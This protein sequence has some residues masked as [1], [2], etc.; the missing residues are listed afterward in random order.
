MLSIGILTHNSPITL[1]NTL[2]SYKIGG[3]LD[4]TNDITCLIQPSNKSD[5]EIEICKTYGIGH[6]NEKT[7]TMMAGAIKTLVEQ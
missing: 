6:I 4:Y 2:E 3:L 1:K 5:E 7:N